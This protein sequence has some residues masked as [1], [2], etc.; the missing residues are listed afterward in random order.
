MSLMVVSMACVG[1]FL[2]QG[3]WP[4]EGVHRKPSL[5]AHPG[6]LVKSEE[7]VI[8]QCWSDVRFEHFLLHREGKFK[9]TLHLIGEHHDGVSKA[10]FSIGPMMQD[11]AGTYR[12][13]GSV[14]HSP[15]QLSAPSDPLDIVITGLY[16]KPSLSAQ[17]GPTV[18]AGESVTLSCSSRS[19]YDMYHLSR[20]GEAHECRFS[21]GPKVN[22]T[23][24]ADFPLGPATHGGTYRCFGSFRDS[25]YE[26]SNSSDPLLVSVIGNPSN[27]WP[28]PTE[29]SSK[30]GNPRHL[31][32]LIGTSVVIILFILLFF[33][34]HRWC[35][36][37]K[38]AAVMDQESAGNR[39]AN[40]E[41]SDEQDPQE[42]TY[43]QLNHCVF[44]Q[45]KITRPSQRP[46]TPPTDI[47]VYAELPNA[48]SRS[49]VVSCP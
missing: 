21:A 1:F 36:N 47:I 27:S 15:Y 11:L 26:W 2:L 31:H 37:K 17:P 41:D 24:Q 3:A 8:L 9:D 35:S 13:Y 5:L 6:R 49:K 44:T 34:L 32:I 29:P 40:S 43:T 45:R 42:V 19:S 25:P 23:F 10:N 22:G 38:N 12:C 4:H 30:T 46:K 33:L 20:E 14:T 18:L 28:S 48:E 7:T 16:E 39:T